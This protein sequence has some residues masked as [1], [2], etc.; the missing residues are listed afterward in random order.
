VL[1]EVGNAFS[2]MNRGAASQFI[3]QCYQTPNIK[4]VS[5]D[6]ALLSRALEL[7]DARP[8]KDWG[9]T[10]CISFMVMS[11]NS[12]INAATADF[13]FVQAGY[14]ALLLEVV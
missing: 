2:A 1:V 14:R 7:Y 8:D 11:E 10:D 3:R 13:H 9:L 5:V 12:L 6:T 4:V